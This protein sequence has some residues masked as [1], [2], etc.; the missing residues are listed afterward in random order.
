M[1]AQ[2]PAS[3]RSPTISRRHVLAG[4]SGVLALATLPRLAFAI[5]SKAPEIIETWV[6]AN[7]FQGVVLLGRSGVAHYARAFG[8]IDIEAH[9]AARIDDVYCIASISK[10]LTTLSVLRLVERGLLDLDAPITKWLPDYRADTGARLTLRRL[11]SNSSGLPK[12]FISAA[13]ADPALLT[14][15]LPAAEAVRRF[16]SGDLY[17]EPGTTF[18]YILENWIIVY[19]IIEAVTGLTYHAAMRALTLD[20]LGLRNTGATAADAAGKMTVPSYR[21]VDP[22]ERRP[23]QRQPFLA[24]AGGFFSDAHD[25]LRA[26]HGVYDKGFLSAASM[27]QLTTVQM[28]TADYALGGRMKTLPIGGK[29]RIFA[30]ETGNTAGYRSV[31]AHQLDTH[32]TMVIL[33]NT[34][35]SQR[36][37]DEFAILTQS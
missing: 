27:R 18:D 19:A 12:M 34:S 37:L 25:L 1:N 7:A 4:T 20:P 22:L 28:P 21:S 14:Q 9:R 11:L 8:M 6:K 3:S 15:D 17:F 13:Q 29:P 32:E 5:A 24:A 26:A 36:V 23:F 2:S 30:W 35:M 31:L 33:N 10:W 16:A